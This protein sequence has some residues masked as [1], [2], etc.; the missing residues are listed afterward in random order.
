MTK[1]RTYV[2]NY[3]GRKG[4]PHVKGVFLEG[5]VTYDWWSPAA[6]QARDA[7]GEHLLLKYRMLQDMTYPELDELM[8]WAEAVRD[9]LELAAD[10]KYAIDNRQFRFVTADEL[11]EE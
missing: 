3:T 1:Q 7:R 4:R 10:L 11:D 8:C 2:S 6:G 5:Y 9:D